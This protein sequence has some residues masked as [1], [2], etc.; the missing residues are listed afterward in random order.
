MI[1]NL[2]R[3][4]RSQDQQCNCAGLLQQSLQSKTWKRY[5]V[6]FH[7]HSKYVYI[8]TNNMQRLISLPLPSDQ[9]YTYLNQSVCGELAT[10]CIKFPNETFGYMCH[11]P[12][13]TLKP[14]CPFKANV[15]ENV[16]VEVPL[17]ASF[18]KDVCTKQH[19]CNNYSPPLI[20]E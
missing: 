9:D 19:S 7:F 4:Y 13:C 20:G 5:Q 11:C 12:G 10:A 18:P 6:Q 17:S 16:T 3:L 14:P 2:T 1:F 15:M 8:C